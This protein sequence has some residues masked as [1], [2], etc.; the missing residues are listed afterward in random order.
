MIFDAP[1][2]KRNRIA[3]T[4]A[5]VLGLGVGFY[6]TYSGKKGAPANTGEASEVK[7]ESAPDAPPTSPK[8]PSTPQIAPVAPGTG[9]TILSVAPPSLPVGAVDDIDFNSYSQELAASFGLQLGE[10]RLDTIDRIRLHFA[11][12]PGT[13]M[14]NL[15]S[16]TFELDDGSVML[17][18]RNDFAR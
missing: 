15:T 14:V 7:L 6:M 10:S 11:P 2:T 1:N 3:A 8:T 17:F 12:E 5:I 13:N 18:A 9:G 16:S 4:I